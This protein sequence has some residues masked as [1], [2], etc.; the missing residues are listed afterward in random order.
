[1][2]WINMVFMVNMVNMDSSNILAPVASVC[3]ITGRKTK[4]LLN[5]TSHLL[6]L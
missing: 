5:F 6:F 3:M 1:M 2:L 4:I